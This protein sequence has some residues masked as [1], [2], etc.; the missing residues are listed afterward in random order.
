MTIYDYLEI[1]NTITFEVYPSEIIG[2][3]FEDVKVVTRGDMNFARL[4][5]ID[6]AAM[7]KN[8]YPF[9]PPTVEN[10]PESYQYVALKHPNGSITVIGVP[11]IK[12][13]TVRI[14]QRGTLILTVEDVGVV[15]RE[16]VVQAL[17]AIGIT[18]AKVELI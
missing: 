10:D 11:W 14:S 7:H 6:P 2:A 12:V 5:G 18:P 15:E 16:R 17:S 13:D 8:V 4:F 1:G 3:R 9:L